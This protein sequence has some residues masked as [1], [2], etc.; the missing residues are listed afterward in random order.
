MLRQV[1]GWLSVPQVVP[2]AQLWQRW[3]IPPCQHCTHSHPPALRCSQDPPRQGGKGQ[4]TSRNPLLSHG[5]FCCDSPFPL[6]PSSTTPLLSSRCPCLPGSAAC[7]TTGPWSTPS[8]LWLQD[9]C[10][11]K[12]QKLLAVSSSWLATNTAPFPPVSH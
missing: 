6:P 5:A 7:S 4:W 2:C 9:L 11:Q 8:T 3:L 12:R 1:P 10:L